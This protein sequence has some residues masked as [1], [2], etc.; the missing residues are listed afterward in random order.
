LNTTNEIEA[1]LTQPWEKAKDLQRPLPD[2]VLQIVA[3]G[4]KK[5]GPESSA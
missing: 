4:V 2:G 1:S 3:R 5:D